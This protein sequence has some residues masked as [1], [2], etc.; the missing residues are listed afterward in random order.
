MK[1]GVWGAEAAR[2]EG[3]YPFY[4]LSARRFG[5]T[6]FSDDAAHQRRL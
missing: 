2:P 1:L 3:A 6:R 4:Q 5:T